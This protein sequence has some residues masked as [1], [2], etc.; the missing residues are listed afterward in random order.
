MNDLIVNSLLNTVSAVVIG[1]TIII[2]A[3]WVITSIVTSMRQ[4]ANTRTR[5]EV[6]NRLIDKFG[7]ATELIAFFESDAGFRFIEEQ[8]VNVSQPVAKII[9]SIRLG[10]SLALIGIGMIIVGNIWDRDL[11]NDLYTAVA[12]GG[13]VSLTAG[14]GFIIAA[15]ISY[16]LCSVLDILPNTGTAKPDAR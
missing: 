8:A 15:A 14:A 10:V 4:R 3:A 6:Y 16:K 5:A 7:T 11:G 13:T 9:G 2:C 1:S 12:L